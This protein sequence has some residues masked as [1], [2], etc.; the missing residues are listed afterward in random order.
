MFENYSNQAGSRPTRRSSTV[1]SA[2]WWTS[3][4]AMSRGR[5][6]VAAGRSRPGGG[7]A[8]RPPGSS[9]AT[10]APA[11]AWRL[12]RQWAPRPP[13]VAASG[14]LGM[15]AALRDVA[16]VNP[17]VHYTAHGRNGPT[18][19]VPYLGILFGLAAGAVNGFRASDARHGR[20]TLRRAVVLAADPAS[21]PGPAWVSAVIRTACAFRRS[22]SA[23]P[24]D[25]PCPHGRDLRQSSKDPGLLSAEP[26]WLFPARGM[27]FRTEA[28]DRRFSGRT[29]PATSSV[30]P[31]RGTSR[32]RSGAN[33]CDWSHATEE[34]GERSGVPSGSRTTP[35][36][37][38]GWWSR[39]EIQRSR[40]PRRVVK[41][42]W[43][44]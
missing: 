42:A 16:L 10:P 32:P 11:P 3:P 29:G 23:S 5:R 26:P 24:A 14:A 2:G 19:R 1:S 41:A 39:N 9:S 12:L 7:S 17:E 34:P 35:R 36:R 27:R 43:L 13:R 28:Y 31:C 18:F 15:F 6:R 40:R 30:M 21:C 38:W 22:S 25:R 33:P 4:I 44:G 8:I 20:L 37:A